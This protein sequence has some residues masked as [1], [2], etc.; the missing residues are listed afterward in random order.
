[1]AKINFTKEH[2]DKMSKLLLKMLISNETLST[3]IGTP[4]NAVELLHTQT[5]N[6]LNG[7]R[8]SLGNRITETENKDEWIST[9]ASNGRLE[10]LKEQKE[11]VNLVIGYKRYKLEQEENA[12]KKELNDNK[13]KNLV[14]NMS[15]QG[16]TPRHYT[17]L[18]ASLSDLVTGSG[19]RATPITIIKNYF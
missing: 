8:I 2:F 4:I 12:I 17:D 14:G 3:K 13:N 11:L 18:L 1:M 6:T 5:I 16:T 10:K 7:M 19:S 9:E 15:S